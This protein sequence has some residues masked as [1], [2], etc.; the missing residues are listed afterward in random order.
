MAIT[1]RVH[2]PGQDEALRSLSVFLRQDGQ[3][4]ARVTLVECPPVEGHLGTVIDMLEI[5]VGSGG[6]VTVLVTALTVWLQNR[7]S[8]ISIEITNAAGAA[9]KLEAKR[10]KL[11]TAEDLENI[12]HK[13]VGELG[14]S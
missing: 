1:V 13:V 14:G 4:H 3:L 5:A 9:T 10:I 2:D 7:H 8:D 11:A 6:A 12:I